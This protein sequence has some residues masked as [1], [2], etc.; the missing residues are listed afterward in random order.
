MVTFCTLIILPKPVSRQVFRMLLKVWN[1]YLLTY[2]K[3]HLWLSGIVQLLI[4]NSHLFD[5]YIKIKYILVITIFWG[6]LSEWGTAVYSI[7]IL[8]FSIYQQYFNILSFQVL[9]RQFKS[10]KN[11]Q[12]FHQ[13][14]YPI[15][16]GIVRSQ[17]VFDILK[18]L[19]PYQQF[20]IYN[21][22]HLYQF[23]LLIKKLSLTKHLWPNL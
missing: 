22:H 18:F 23:V 8:Y 1:W 10:S 5:L 12:F 20:I 17:I 15:L 7:I 11:M 3:S 2:Q 6:S 9:Q 14:V 19:K 13:F 4:L 16:I 21:L